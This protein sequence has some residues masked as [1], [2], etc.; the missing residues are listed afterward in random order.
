M[1]TAVALRI[2]TG[3]VRLLTTVR[4]HVLGSRRGPAQTLVSRPSSHV[5]RSKGGVTIEQEA[6]HVF[7]VRNDRVIHMTGYTDFQEALRIVRG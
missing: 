6:A 4:E 2:R 3:I 7:T 5:L 1:G